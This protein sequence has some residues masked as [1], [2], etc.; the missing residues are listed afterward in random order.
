MC[1]YCA[2]FRS[3]SSFRMEWLAGQQHVA[4]GWLFGALLLALREVA[5]E[6]AQAGHIHY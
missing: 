2:L 5:E 4:S 1:L 6:A 3:S